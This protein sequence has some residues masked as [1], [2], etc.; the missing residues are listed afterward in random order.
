MYVAD[1]WSMSL[2]PP[3]GIKLAV[4]VFTSLSCY[5]LDDLTSPLILNAEGAFPWYTCRWSNIKP[6]DI[7]YE[8]EKR[9]LSHKSVMPNQQN[10]LQMLTPSDINNRVMG[11]TKMLLQ[12]EIYLFPLSLEWGLFSFLGTLAV[13]CA[14]Q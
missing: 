1:T 8:T 11:S 9:S 13:F 3:D 14:A 12:N 4:S 5:F 10:C 6:L 2:L 7:S